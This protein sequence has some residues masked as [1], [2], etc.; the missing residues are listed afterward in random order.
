VA[1]ARA[2]TTPLGELTV[3]PDPNPRLPTVFT[4]LASLPEQ[5]TSHRLS[6]PATGQCNWARV[7]TTG[8]GRVGVGAATPL[9]C[10]DG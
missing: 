3:E 2:E 1:D 8:Y 6:V 4:E 5:R 7:V 9:T 10:E